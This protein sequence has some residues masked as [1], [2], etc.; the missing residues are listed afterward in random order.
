MVLAFLGSVAIYLFNQEE[1]KIFLLLPSI[2]LSG[3]L[4]YIFWYSQLPMHNQNQISVGSM[5]PEVKLRN[6]NG[7]GV[8]NEQFDGDFNVLL[9]YRG[10]W[11]PLCMAQIKELS[12][13]YQTLHK[14][15]A[16]LFLIS[17]QPSLKSQKLAR[18]YKVALNFLQDPNAKTAKK[19]RIYHKNGTPLGMELFGYSPDT[20]LPTVIIVDKNH[21]IIYIAQTDNYR[22]RPLPATY[23]EAIEK[24][25]HA[26][27][28]PQSSS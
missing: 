14:A 17:P 2:G 5:L 12:N 1:I 25:K 13:S 19:F 8:G 21:E 15:G 22:I 27:S 26:N 11:C 16:K 23:L 20:V 28:S 18:K 4:L 10:N 24:W 7:H 9:F 6:M 3:W